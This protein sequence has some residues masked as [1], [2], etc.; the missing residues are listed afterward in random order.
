MLSLA[1]APHLRRRRGKGREMHSFRLG[2]M[3]EAGLEREA[4]EYRVAEAGRLARGEPTHQ[5]WGPGDCPI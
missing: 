3:S 2:A 1:E 5:R 4:M